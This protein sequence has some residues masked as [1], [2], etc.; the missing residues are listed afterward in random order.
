MAIGGGGSTTARSDNIR[1]YNFFHPL[2]GSSTGRG[3][4]H[5][6]GTIEVRGDT[7]CKTAGLKYAIYA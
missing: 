7:A 4:L 3:T 5:V 6:M 2:R 1:A